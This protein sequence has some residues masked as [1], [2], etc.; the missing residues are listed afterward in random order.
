MQIEVSCFPPAL[1]HSKEARKEQPEE[2]EP[3]NRPE[4]PS[5]A[6]WWA[7][8]RL[9]QPTEQN[10]TK[11]KEALVEIAAEMQSTLTVSFLV[12]FYTP[13][14]L[15]LSFLSNDTEYH[16]RAPRLLSSLKLFLSLLSPPPPP[17][18]SS[19]HRQQQQQQQQS[20]TQPR[21]AK[22][23]PAAAAAA[24]GTVCSLWTDHPTIR[25]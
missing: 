22:P 4:G 10:R 7:R 23:L 5:R 19:R 21:R 11:P 12:F 25:R 14:L 13:S 1:T 3:V 20:K 6:K 17:P 9:V 2:C 8:K 18:L 15:I 16:Q 24:A